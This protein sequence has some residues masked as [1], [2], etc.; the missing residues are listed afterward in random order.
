MFPGG[1]IDEQ[2]AHSVCLRSFPL[3]LQPFYWGDQERASV[4]RPG[5]CQGHS[6]LLL[7]NHL[8]NFQNLR[9][10]RRN[11]LFTHKPHSVTCPA[12]QCSVCSGPTKPSQKN[13]SP[14]GHLHPPPRGTKAA[15]G[16]RSQ[17]NVSRFLPSL[18]LPLQEART[19]AKGSVVLPGRP[20]LRPQSQN[21][22][23]TGFNLCDL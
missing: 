12:Q 17:I 18:S 6:G 9:E 13:S 2:L 16:T 15:P 7:L 1:L 11:S 21:E 19:A 23:S 5:P 4:K 20:E 22:G 14:G 8:I 3:W 10:M